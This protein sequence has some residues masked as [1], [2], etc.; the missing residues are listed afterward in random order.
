MAVFG[1][2]RGGASSGG[3]GTVTSVGA[4]PPANGIGIAGSPITTN[5]TF[6]FSLT[7]DLAAVEGLAATGIVRRTATDTWSAGGVITVVEGGT[8]LSAIAQG[9]IL[10]G[11]G[12]NTISALVKNASATRYLSN[13]GT[14]NNP[15]WAQVD[16][17]NGVVGILPSANGGTANGFTKFAGPAASEKTF[18]LPNASAVILTDAAAVTPVQGGTGLTSYTTGDILYAS[19][20]NVL[21]KLAATTNGYVLTLA[22]GIPSWVAP[23]G[24]ITIASTAITSGTAGRVLFQ[25]SSNQVAQKTG[26]FW[27]N[28]NDRLGINTESPGQRLHVKASSDFDGLNV[29]TTTTSP[30]LRLMS[31]S[32]NSGARNYIF[33][34]NI[35]SF[36]D[37]QIWQ[38]SSS[39]GTPIDHPVFTIL[40]AF[41]GL[42]TSIPSYNADVTGTLRSTT[43]AHLA[44]TGGNVIIGGTTA[45]TSAVKGLHIYTGTAPSASIVDGVVM[46]SADIVAGNAAMHFRTE[47]GSIIRLFQDIGWSPVTGTSQKGGWD[48]ATVSHTD[49]AETVKAIVDHLDIDHCALLDAGPP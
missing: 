18:T 37:F 16:L 3:S 2:T 1:Q 47:V 21:S 38:S 11:S 35:T 48:T 24:G 7:N 29:E 17:T 9:D 27:D 19:A 10:Y 28:T 6:V 49:L 25:N 44:T 5:G 32:G 43:S 40:G 14:S 30:G 31:G 8:G 12:V 41:I 39:G 4:T 42:N 15:A 36:G 34:T 20:T 45:A 13:T 23:G 33:M 46:Y 26:F 22:S